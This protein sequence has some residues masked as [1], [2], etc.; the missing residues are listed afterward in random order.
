M[1]GDSLTPAEK[2]LSAALRAAF[3]QFASQ[4]DPSTV[5]QQWAPWDSTVQALNIF[6]GTGAIVKVRLCSDVFVIEQL[7]YLHVCYS[8]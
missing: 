2:A 1:F 7:I 6:N 8:S 4:G 3:V 5:S